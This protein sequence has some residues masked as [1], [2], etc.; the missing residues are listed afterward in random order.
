MI[1]SNNAFS[2][3]HIRKDFSVPPFLTNS[4][5]LAADSETNHRNSTSGFIPK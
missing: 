4:A 5:M 1:N 3:K 2:P